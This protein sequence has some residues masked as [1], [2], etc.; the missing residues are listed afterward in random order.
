MGKL[1]GLY[2]IVDF[3]GALQPRSNSSLVAATTAGTQ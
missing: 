2:E 3:G 1:V